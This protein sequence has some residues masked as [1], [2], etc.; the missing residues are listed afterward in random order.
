M[1]SLVN[2]VGQ[3]S[4]TALFQQIQLLKLKIDFLLLISAQMIL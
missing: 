2:N 3:E 1:I 4:T